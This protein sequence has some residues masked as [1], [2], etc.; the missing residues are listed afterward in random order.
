LERHRN[1]SGMEGDVVSDGVF[2]FCTLDTEVDDAEVEEDDEDI[3]TLGWFD[4][5]RGLFVASLFTLLFVTRFSF[6]FS[7]CS[8][9]LIM[10]WK[11]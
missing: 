4:F 6:F 8:C 7:S 10:D 9:C 5:L 2:E 11:G 3:F 1:V